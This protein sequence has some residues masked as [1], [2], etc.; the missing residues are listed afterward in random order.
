MVFPA[1][2]QW[3][4]EAREG[5][6]DVRSQQH[7]CLN[8]FASIRHNRWPRSPSSS[9]SSGLTNPLRGS[10][11][12]SPVV[13]LSSIQTWMPFGPDPM[14]TLHWPSI[15]LSGPSRGLISA[16]GILRQR[17]YPSVA[18]GRSGYFAPPCSLATRRG[19]RLRADGQVMVGA[20]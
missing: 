12:P 1:G 10:A 18:P 16:C 20:R 14:G 6:W 15:T 3:C 9:P 2:R 11:S 7:S 4:V 13:Y 19:V 17:H 5:P 8:I